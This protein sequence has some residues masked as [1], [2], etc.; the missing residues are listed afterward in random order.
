MQV[1]IGVVGHNHEFAQ[2]D[3]GISIHEG[4]PLVVG[5]GAVSVQ[6]HFPV[7]DVS[8]K[9]SPLVAAN[10]D[11]ESISTAIIITIKA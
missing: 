1:L 3:M 6:V 11:E 8:K 2:V 10:G 7:G 5:K 4:E 9:V